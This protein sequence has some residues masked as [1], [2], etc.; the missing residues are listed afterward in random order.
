MEAIS[1]PS[2]CYTVG[3]VV[4]ETETAITLAG[5]YSANQSSGSMC[6]P[7]AAILRRLKVKV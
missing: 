5:S 4:K 7:K 3:F 1:E 2:V 6:I